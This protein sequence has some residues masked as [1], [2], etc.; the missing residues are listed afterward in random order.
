MRLALHCIGRLKDGPD[1]DLFA[2]YWQRL[3]VQGRSLGLA[4]PKLVEL[5]ECRDRSAPVRQED[6]AQRLVKGLAPHAHLIA[7][8]ERGKALTSDGFAG[9]IRKLR[10]A[11]TPD[12]AFALGG[13]DGH[14]PTIQIGR[15]HV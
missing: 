8:D 13:P 5:P 15:A 1:R 12:V 14:G 4:A 2:R 7:L 9:F 11:G 3:E 10:D 6:E